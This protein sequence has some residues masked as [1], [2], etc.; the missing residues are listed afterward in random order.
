MKTIQSLFMLCGVSIIAACS[1][2][3]SI[4]DTT[5]KDQALYNEYIADCTFKDGQTAAPK[6]ICGY[7]IDDYPVTETGYSESGSESEAKARALVKL[8]GRIQTVVENEATLTSTST[9]R[10]SDKSFEE[11]SRQFVKERLNNTRVLLRMV[12]PSTQGLHVLVVAEEDAFDKS[13]RSAM[14][15]SE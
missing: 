3:N 10:R 12:D 5:A 7:P 13:L 6:W 1:S 11:V 9:N 8:A 4:L 2:S 14:M 15:K